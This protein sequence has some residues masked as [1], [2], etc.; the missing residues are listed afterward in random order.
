MTSAALE[1]APPELH[2]VGSAE[3][4]APGEE[5]DPAGPDSWEAWSSRAVELVRPL[6]AD[7][8]AALPGVESALVC[9]ADGFA[10]CGRGL[11]EGAV[12]R[13][14]AMASSLTSLAAAAT[15]PVTSAAPSPA[16]AH[17]EAADASV[18]LVTLVHG[19]CLTVVLP[20][21]LADD[22]LLL[23]VTVS[24]PTLG[25]LLYHAELTSDRIRAAL[26]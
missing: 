19:S 24:G 18:A 14:S 2:A 16:P 20:V 10:L 3:R 7:L 12:R 26:S 21:R 9:T 23:A 5:L 4:H 8:A 13:V 22:D 11:D 6:L 1:G 25:T 17:A 15:G